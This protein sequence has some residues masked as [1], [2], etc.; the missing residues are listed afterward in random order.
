MEDSNQKGF[1]QNIVIIVILLA[2]VFFSQQIYFRES[3]KNLYL[4]ADKYARVYIGK[5]S[6][7]LKINVYPKISGEVQKGGVE[8]QKEIAKQKNNLLQ[9]I[10]ENL[11]KYSAEKFSKTFGTK[12]E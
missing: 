12:V 6:D 2:I 1:V 3:G 9:N 10:W 8:A 5:A 7:W 4:Q 11:K